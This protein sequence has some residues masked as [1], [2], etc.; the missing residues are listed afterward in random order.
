MFAELF[1]RTCPICYVEVQMPNL[2]KHM[3]WHIDSK[4]V[5]PERMA[6]LQAEYEALPP[7]ERA[8]RDEIVR[9]FREANTQ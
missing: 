6:E 9:A 7:E 5:T 2:E 1:Q 8:A 4:T 3:Q